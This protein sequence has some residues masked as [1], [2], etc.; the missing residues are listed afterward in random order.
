MRFEWE[1]RCAT[2]VYKLRTGKHPGPEAERLRAGRTEVLGAG[3]ER[4][5]LVA[6]LEAKACL[7]DERT[8]HTCQWTVLQHHHL[9][10]FRTTVCH[11]PP[12]PPSLSQSQSHQLPAQLLSSS[13][14]SFASFRQSIPLLVLLHQRHAH[15]RATPH[16]RASLL[17]QIVAVAVAVAAAA[18]RN[19]APPHHHH[20]TTPSEA[21]LINQ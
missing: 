20:L 6:V 9:L 11:H 19:P 5:L 14:R 15:R 17:S 16:V 13:Q 10:L 8:H 2:V 4:E 3:G 12:P 7:V 18:C 1:T 21:T